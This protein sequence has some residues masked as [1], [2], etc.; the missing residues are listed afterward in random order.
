MSRIDPYERMRDI[1]E[2]QKAFGFF[3]PTTDT[4]ICQLFS[5]QVPELSRADIARGLG[6]SKSPRLRAMLAELVA[7]GRLTYRFIRLPNGVDMYVYS[8]TEIGDL[9]VNG[10]SLDEARA[11][12]TEAAERAVEAMYS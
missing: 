12:S 9:W 8:L 2:H 1:M 6:R 4:D 7:D 3:Q 5:P 10:A 11:M